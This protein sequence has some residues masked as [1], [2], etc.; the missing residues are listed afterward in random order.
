[1]AA[2]RDAAIHHA[3]MK[4]LRLWEWQVGLVLEGLEALNATLA[5]IEALKGAER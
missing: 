3:F 4:R 2:E 5:K 1:M